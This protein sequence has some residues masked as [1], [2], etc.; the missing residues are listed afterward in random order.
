METNL[1]IYQL[2]LAFIALGVAAAGFS[3]GVLRDRYKDLVE[4]L[5]DPEDRKRWASQLSASTPIHLR[6]SLSLLRLNAN[7]KRIYARPLSRQAFDRSL[8]FTMVYPFVLYLVAW[9]A[10]DVSHYGDLVFLGSR[11]AGAERLFV[12]A[13][14]LGTVASAAWVIRATPF[15][16]DMFVYDGS[17]V[18]T[19]LKAREWVRLGI[20]AISFVLLWLFNQAITGVGYALS[21]AVFS[22]LSFSTYFAWRALFSRQRQSSPILAGLVIMLLIAFSISA[23]FHALGTGTMAF[24]VLFFCL[25]PMANAFFDFLSWAVTR[26]FL[27]IAERLQ[28]NRKSYIVLIRGL[29]VDFAWAIL[30][31]CALTFSLGLVMKSYDLY[32]SAHQVGWRQQ[33]ESI[34]AGFSSNGL[35]I[36]G[37][38]ATTIV[39]TLIHLFVGLF[40][41]LIAFVPRIERAVELLMLEAPS[42]GALQEAARIVQFARLATVA[43]PVTVAVIVGSLPSLLGPALSPFASRIAVAAVSALQ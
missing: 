2:V 24:I 5:G 3:R 8:I 26:W 13:I 27:K 31:L 37:M 34:R 39:P 40:G 1:S 28:P 42:I 36:Y 9:T 22:I 18:L 32:F 17:A 20:C 43:V 41:T 15:S 7:V 10:G 14:F 4:Q 25:L 38:L 21:F 29:A 35:L 12:A 23:H 19:R 33:L 30:C 16:E 6:Y 11:L